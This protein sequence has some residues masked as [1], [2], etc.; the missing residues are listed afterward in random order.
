[1]IIAIDGPSGAGKSSW[2]A[3]IARELKL[4][5][6]D[7][8]QCTVPRSAVIESGVSTRDSRQLRSRHQSRHQSR[9]RPGFLQVMLDG[10]DISQEIRTEEVSHRRP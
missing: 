3:W 2:D 10:R 5:D 1:M 8:A 4:L 9:R 6:I 7:R